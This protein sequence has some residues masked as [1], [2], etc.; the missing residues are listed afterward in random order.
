MLKLQKLASAFMLSL[1]TAGMSCA[2]QPT[3]I[4]QIVVDQLRADL[5]HKHRKQ[6]TQNGF[7]ALLR[8]GVEYRNAYHPHA[9]T[10]TCAGHTTIA[11]GSYPAYHG[12]VDNEWYDPQ[13]KREIYCVE[14]TN[15]RLLKNRGKATAL[16]GRSPLNIKAS[17]LSDELVLSGKG[18]A[19]AV[20]FKD[21]GAIT[22]AGHAGKAFWFDKE[23]GGFISS[24]F[25]YKTLPA[26]LRDWNKNYKADNYT[27]QL[28]KPAKSYINV[29]SPTLK[30]DLKSFNATFPHKLKRGDPLYFKNLSRTPRADELT[31]EVAKLLLTHEKIGQKKQYTDYLAISFSSFDAIGHEFGPN[32]LE[33][34]DDLIRLDKTIAELIAALDKKVG[35]ANTLIIF[36]A[37]H[38]VNET[39]TY[40]TQHHLQKAKPNNIRELSKTIRTILH[41]QFGLPAKALITLSLPYVYLDHTII[42]KHHQS[43]LAVSQI[44]AHELGY[45][46]DVFRAYALPLADHTTDWL[47]MKVSKMYFPS[48]TGD[49]YLVP[50][51]NQYRPENGESQVTHGSPWVYD[52]YVPLFFSHPSFKHQVISRKVY[53]IDIAQTLSQILNIKA[54]SAATGDPLQEVLSQ[55]NTD[56]TD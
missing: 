30:H 1:M 39:P 6:F 7:N 55:M 46:N 26:W 8:H 38:G 32:S 35:L 56:N 34:E 18:K 28:D 31:L 11:T 22:L 24:T 36:S 33:A 49:L 44:L 25:Y 15:A 43:S 21:R 20:S 3:L 23:D 50:Q 2:S 9:N 53:T 4:V 37:D 51:P 27:W 52:S 42:S 54:P 19:Y 10:T 29:N 13:K 16:Q 41:Q 14:D 5:I 12:I 48:R 47:G 40:L 17:T 45:K